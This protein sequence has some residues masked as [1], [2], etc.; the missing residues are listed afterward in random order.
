[1][2]ARADA[3]EYA[4]FWRRLGALIIDDFLYLILTAPLGYTLFGRAWFG[5]SDASAMPDMQWPYYAADLALSALLPLALVVAFWHTMGATPGKLLMDCKVVGLRT[6]ERPGLLQATVRALAYIISA[7]PLGL[8]FFWIAW[9]K[10]KQGWHDKI[11]RTAVMHRIDDYEHQ[12]L[13][14]L[15]RPFQ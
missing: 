9:D 2:K 1:M 14:A 15:M 6:G 8:G 11:A 5:Q 10:R 3:V 7:L 4:G 12:S 13:A